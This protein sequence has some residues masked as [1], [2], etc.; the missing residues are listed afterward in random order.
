MFEN[1]YILLLLTKNHRQMIWHT[2]ALS[3]NIYLKKN[4]KNE[5]WA[6][7]QNDNLYCPDYK[8]WPS[9]SIISFFLFTADVA[10]CRQIANILA[11]II[12]KTEVY[13]KKR[14]ERKEEKNTLTS[15][16]HLDCWF[17][18]VEKTNFDWTKIVEVVT[19]GKWMF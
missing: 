18:M 14:Q 3:L 6:Q 4:V 10:L 7:T 8:P 1:W 5:K 19:R 11:R 9:S 13:I 16:H 12:N 2:L 17:I 15:K